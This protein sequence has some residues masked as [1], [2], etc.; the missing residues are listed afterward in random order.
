MPLNAAQARESKDNRTSPLELIVGPSWETTTRPLS[1]WATVLKRGEDLFL[2]SILLVLTAPAMLV[3][4]ALVK[5]DSRGPVFFSQRRVGA[6]GQV[7]KVHKFRT[8]HSHLADADAERQTSRHDMRVTR[9]GAV[10]RRTSLDE[11]P[12]LL[13]VLLGTMSIV[14]PR[15]HALKTTAGGQPLETAVHNYH[16]R[17]RIKPGITGLAQVSGQRGE[18]DSLE[19]AIARVQY[20]LKYIENW[21]LL[22][23]LMIVAR[24]VTLIFTDKNAY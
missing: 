21:S 2:A 7:I 1:A 4:A 17:F 10:L 6:H 23:D 24:T 19:K 16:L 15:P 20:D 13:N 14:G 12:Q 11:L 18:L 8:M 5:I 9:F 3:I 22:L